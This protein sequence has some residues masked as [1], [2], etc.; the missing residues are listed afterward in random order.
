[1]DD[2]ELQKVL[3]QRIFLNSDDAAIDALSR[4]AERGN[5]VG[6]VIYRD[7]GGRH[8][9]SEPQG[10]KNSRAFSATVTMPKGSKVSGVYHTHPGVGPEASLAEYFPQHDMDVA[11]QLKVASYIRAMQ[12]GNIRKYMP[13]VSPTRYKG[14]GINRVKVSQG[15]LLQQA[16]AQ[17]LMRDPL[18]IAKNAK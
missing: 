9:Y 13:G 6:G 3:A 1:M 8:M 11:D 2:L 4:I 16:L 15:E 12:S 7:Q 14:S 18:E 17:E 5:E 10:Q